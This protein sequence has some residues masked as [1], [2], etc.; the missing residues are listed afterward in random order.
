MAKSQSA[1]K[2]AA[3]E[4]SA[5]EKAPNPVKAEASHPGQVV[6]KKYM[7]HSGRPDM[8]I[9]NLM[10]SDSFAKKKKAEEAG[11]LAEDARFAR[12]FLSA[13]DARAESVATRQEHKEA[14]E[15]AVADGRVADKKGRYHT[16]SEERV[17]EILE[18]FI[19]LDE[20][21]GTNFPYG[22]EVYLDETSPRI[23]K[24]RCMKI[25]EHYKAIK[26]QKEGLEVANNDESDW[27]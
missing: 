21:L 22:Q 12:K 9:V 3:V 20:S 11:T 6:F 14:Y 1:P 25:R 19:P 13:D 5:E 27:V 23:N 4:E 7:I 24:A 18:T 17:F 15:K 16:D 2:G 10:D 8:P 26:D